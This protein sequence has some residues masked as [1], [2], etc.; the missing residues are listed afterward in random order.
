MKG[1]PKEQRRL[2]EDEEDPY[3]SEE[4]VRTV[5]VSQWGSNEHGYPP[6]IPC[7]PTLHSSVC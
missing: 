5:C 7:E 3:M 2:Q 1:I 6:S 4:H